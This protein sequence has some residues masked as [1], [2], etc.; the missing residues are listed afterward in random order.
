[1]HTKVHAHAGSIN[2][3]LIRRLFFVIVQCLTHDCYSDLIVRLTKETEKYI[4]LHDSNSNC[5]AGPL[6]NTMGEPPCKKQCSMATFFQPCLL[7]KISAETSTM[8]LMMKVFCHTHVCEQNLR[9]NY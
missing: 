2:I 1:M 8:R 7:R 5:P 4:F 3:N 6:C 9:V